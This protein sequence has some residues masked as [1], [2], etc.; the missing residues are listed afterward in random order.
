MVWK[1]VDHR[2]DSNYECIVQINYTEK[3]EFYLIFKMKMDD[4][5]IE[6]GNTVCYRAMD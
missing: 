1:I 5:P 4:F 6:I 3:F 2:Q